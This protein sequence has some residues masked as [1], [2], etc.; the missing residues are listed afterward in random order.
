MWFAGVF[1][2]VPSVVAQPGPVKGGKDQKPG[3]P[4]DE[5]RAIHK[6]VVDAYKAPDEVDKDVLDELRKQYTN[7]T[8]DRE[9]KIFR[10]IRRLYATTPQLEDAIQYE[11]RRAYENP[12]HLQEE[13][14]FAV[15]RR[16]GQLPLGTVPAQD[17]AEKAAKLFRKLDQNGDGFLSPEEM[18]DTLLS[19]YRQFDRN[20]DGAISLEEYVHYYQAYLKWVADGVASG[21]IPLKVGKVSAKSETTPA[22]KPVEPPRPAPTKVEK[23][24]NPLPAWFAQ[25]D[26][27]GDG[28]IGLY[29]WKA[30]GGQVADF[31]A[32][33][34]N[35]DGFLEPDEVR[36]YLAEQHH[37]LDP[38]V[39]SSRSHSGH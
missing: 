9:A 13:R 36:L 26:T 34:R 21:E 17:M 30:A 22:P 16:G 12:S 10:E 39:S 31:L 33:D 24:P 23:Q 1:L 8:P 15:M 38:S 3:P 6:E 27:D 20:H 7:P 5:F 29:E 2:L 18:S 14:V 35:G 11:L 25:L 37:S 19:Q 28:Q 4:V 32:M